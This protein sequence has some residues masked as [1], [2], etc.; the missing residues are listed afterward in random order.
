M[1]LRSLFNNSGTW[2]VVTSPLIIS[3]FLILLNV[4]LIGSYTGDD[5]Y[6]HFTYMRNLAEAGRFAYNSADPTY[7]SSSIAWVV[8]GAACS[9]ITGDVPLTARIL[10]GTLFVL[11][12]WLL[13][14]YMKSRFLPKASELWWY[15]LVFAGSAVGFRWLL[16]GMETN[17]V[18]FTTLIILLYYNP[19]R[20]LRCALLSLLAYLVRPEFALIPLSHL[21]V[22]ILDGRWT[23]K[24]MLFVAVSALLFLGWMFLAFLYFGSA[25]PLTS[26]KSTSG[27]SIAMLERLVKVLGGTFPFLLLV[28][29][30]GLAVPNWRRNILHDWTFNEKVLAV[31]VP[32]LLV[33]YATTGTGVLSR[34]LS[35]IH[36]P[37]FVVF[38]YSVSRTSLNRWLPQ[39]TI[40][41]LI[42]ESVLFTHLHFD[43]IN[44][45]ASE[46]QSVYTEIG[47]T[48]AI[49]DHQD[50]SMVML[51]DVGMV[52]F[53]SRR[54]ILDL[55]GLTSRHVHETKTSDPPTLA[56]KFLPRY[57]VLRLDQLPYETY[58]RDFMER[59]D[60]VD[61]VSVLNRYE[62]GGWGVLNDR[63]WRVYVL[64]LHYKLHRFETSFSP[65]S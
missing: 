39:V 48:L 56:R 19:E 34:Y 3:L 51:Q 2:S 44:R 17:L 13:V 45:F 12:C 21:L 36:V 43:H 58:I 32:L 6:I 1:L 61:S 14:S 7:G 29:A 57:F 24:A 60:S 46:F 52:A 11:V 35:M 47:R 28:G 62:V 55:V 9:A 8:L 25:L 10:S 54:P 59:S 40:I 42:I 26:L 64:E 4:S 33:A 22:L 31:F 41:A 63:M 18:E 37:L 30:L 23:R 50:S 53:H 5:A 20:P 16:T 49:R 15:L 27:P 38:V 65:S